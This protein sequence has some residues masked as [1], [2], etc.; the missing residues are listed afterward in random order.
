[1]L[2]LKMYLNY[3]KIISLNLKKMIVLKDDHF[4]LFIKKNHSKTN[5]FYY[6]KDYMSFYC[7]NFKY[8]SQDNEKMTYN[9]TRY[10]YIYVHI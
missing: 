8:F 2:R 5:T 1:M 3:I 4:S 10:F 7:I 9:L 6:L